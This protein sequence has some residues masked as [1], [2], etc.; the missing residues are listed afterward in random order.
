LSGA[1]AAAIA[2]SLQT[3][4]SGSDTA[5]RNRTNAALVLVLASPE[6]IVQK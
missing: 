6:Y 4:P 5:R 1:S 2:A 3:M